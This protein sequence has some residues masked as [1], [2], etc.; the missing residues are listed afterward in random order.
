MLLAASLD[1]NK[2]PDTFGW[3]QTYT[4][5]R[6]TLLNPDPESIVIEDIAHA[7][8][9]QCRFAGHCLRFYSVAEHCRLMWERALF[10]RRECLLHDATE[11]YLVD[12]PRAVKALIPDYKVIEH[13]LSVSIA[14]RFGL[15]YPWP[16]N[17][18]DLDNRILLDERSQNMARYLRPG[19]NQVLPAGYSWGEDEADGW[20]FHLEPLHIRLHYWSPGEAEAKFLEAFYQNGFAREP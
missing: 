11:A 16:D 8:A 12:V 20:P 19:P 5:R 6:F 14:K 4:G 10:Y 18:H 9:N 17:V 15:T 3:I 1:G 7:L 2:V 13:N